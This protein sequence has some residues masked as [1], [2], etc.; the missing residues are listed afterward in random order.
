MEL[1]TNYKRT[2]KRKFRLCEHPWLSLL[3]VVTASMFSI[4]LCGTVLFGVLRLPDDAAPVQF[5]QQMAFHVLTGFILAPF[6]LRLP[7]G[8]RT[9]RQYLDD[10][11][12]S[13]VRPF[14]RLVLLALSCSAILALSQAAG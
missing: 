7:R 2:E 9:F 14:A 6:V 8:K 12:L 5:A 1:P 11:G 10:I 13:R 4:F 3:A